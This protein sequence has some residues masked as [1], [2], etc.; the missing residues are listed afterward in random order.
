MAFLCHGDGGQGRGDRARIGFLASFENG[1]DAELVPVWFED[2]G[3]HGDARAGVL[4]AVA[5]GYAE[6][7]Q[8]ER[9][10]GLPKPAS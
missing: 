4:I 9:H 3:C 7:G 6:L 2:M 5:R 8:D 10:Q 1:S